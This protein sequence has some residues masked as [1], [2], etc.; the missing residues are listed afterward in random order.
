MKRLILLAALVGLAGSAMAQVSV[1][2]M[3]NGSG[4]PNAQG[5]ENAE[6]WGNDIYHAPQYMPGYPTA[7]VIYPRVV[8]VTCEKSDAGLHCKGY[9]WSTDMGRGEYL[10]IQPEVVAK[11][12]P[13]ATVQ[14]PVPEPLMAPTPVFTPVPVPV[15]Q[16]TRKPRKPSKTKVPVQCVNPALTK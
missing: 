14:Q 7:A 15:H 3:E 2:R 10:M 4:Q 13:P 11:A 1:D 8:K 5:V 6:L 12:V 16:L 9:N